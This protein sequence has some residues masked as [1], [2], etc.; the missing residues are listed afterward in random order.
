MNADFPRIITLLRKEKGLSQKHAAADLHISQA[1]LS[2][3]E[4][5]IRECGL[6]FL[7]K[8]ADYYNVSCDYLLGRSPEPNGRQILI[9]DIPE[10]DMII[11]E[12]S[13]SLG[14]IPNLNKKLI[15]ASVNVVYDL[16]QKSKNRALMK[17]CSSILMLSVYRVFRIL[18]SANYKN[19]KNFFTV[20]QVMASNSAKAAESC[21]EARAMAIVSGVEM[22]GIDSKLDKD[23]LLISNTTLANEYEQYAPSLLSLI[24]NSEAHIQLINKAEN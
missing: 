13:N 7:V 18:F 21:A 24:Q 1:L 11:K 14:V 10:Q 3:Y 20:P 23:S 12:S 4:K 2:H 6:D 15:S 16:L 22:D 5:G 9:D 17:E 19:D 8:I